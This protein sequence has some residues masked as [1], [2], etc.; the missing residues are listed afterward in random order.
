MFA[1]KNNSPVRQHGCNEDEYRYELLPGG[2]IIRIHL[3]RIPRHHGQLLRYPVVNDPL[4]V[5][6]PYLFKQL[7]I[8]AIRVTWLGRKMELELSIV[9]AHVEVRPECDVP[10]DVFRGDDGRV[11]GVKHGAFWHVLDDLEYRRFANL[12]T[13]YEEALRWQEFARVFETWNY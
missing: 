10:E 6:F 4:R 8:T 7:P 1:T 11:V 5:V 9:V 3:V 2:I 13:G 12:A